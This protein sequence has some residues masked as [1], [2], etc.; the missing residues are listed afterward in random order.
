[1]REIG[2]PAWAPRATA[3]ANLLVR[4]GMERVLAPGAELAK[5]A[6]EMVDT[7]LVRLP[8]IAE[9]VPAP[10]RARSALRRPRPEQLLP[11]AYHVLVVGI[12]AAAGYPPRRILFLAAAVAVPWAAFYLLSCESRADPRRCLNTDAERTAWRAVLWQ[13]HLF[14]TTGVAAAITGGTRSP[15]LVTV[16]AAYFGAVAVSGDRRATRWLI[17]ATA[18]A[19]AVL[20]ALPRAWTGPDLPAPAYAALTVMSVL[21]VGALLT[22]AHA[23]IR[24]TRAHFARTCEEMASDALTQAQT[25]EQIGSKVAH[26][27][28]NPLTGVKAL[29]Q[30]GL[31]N[32]GEA[33]SHERLEVVEREV[34]R[35]QDILQNY[36]SFTRPMQGM[37]PRRVDLGPLV[38]DTL[39]VL[40]AR[41][42]YAR[43]RL[44]AQGDAEIEADPRRLKEALMNLV[45][46]AIEA[47]PPGGEV[48]VEVKP[49]GDETEILIRDTGRGMPA[50]TLRRLG[51]PFFTTREDGTGL[52]VVLARTAIA[53][54]GG[55]LRYDSEPG[56]GTRVKVTLPRVATGGRDGACAARR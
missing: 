28:K 40:S 49:S 4:V 47:T 2:G 52:G 26:E 48:M 19:V 36:L 53:Q 30:L 8:A 24:K 7:T 27:L 18:L 39:V 54:H 25:L 11:L 29:V 38:S 42:D 45:A 55:S 6:G 5:A 41:A 10:V 21:G 12:L 33:A 1:M 56:R 43:V 51:T 37:A 46:N 3:E 44:Y 31:R 50:E 32:P 17:A 16:T 34:T 22:P 23:W 35:M 15:L 20:A 9:P 13:S 14:L